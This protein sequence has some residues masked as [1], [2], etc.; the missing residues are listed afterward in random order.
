MM[1]GSIPY[2]KA[3]LLN[4]YNKNAGGDASLILAYQLITAT[5]NIANGAIAPQTILD[6]IVA[7]DASIRS[8]I[9][10]MKLKTNHHWVKP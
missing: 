6:A 9:I 8:N 5:L 10:S 3:A 2:D 4:I 7:A 1:L